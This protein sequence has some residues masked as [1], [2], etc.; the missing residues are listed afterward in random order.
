VTC[1]VVFAACIPRPPG[2]FYDAPSPLKWGKP[3]DLIW[4]EPLPVPTGAN[5][6]AWRVMY[7]SRDSDNRE[8]AVTGTVFLPLDAPPPGGW[9]IVSFAHGTSG[10]A[11]KCAPS[12]NG[13]STNTWG[14][15]GI[16]VATDY[17]GLGPTGQR[18][19]F[20]SGEAEG[21]SVIDIVR[22]VR[23]FP[24]AHA[25]RRWV[26]VGVSQGGHAS[27]FAGE[28]ARKYAPELKLEGVVADAPGSGLLDTYPD[29]SPLVVN[30]ITMMAL[31]G[32]AVDHPQIRPED[33]VTPRAA[34]A[35]KVL[36]TGCLA[37]FA[38]A[39]A[40]IPYEE[41]FTADPRTTS[42]AREAAEKN[43]PGNSPIGA[44]VLLVQGTADTTV[45]PARTDA[46]FQKLCRCGK[47]IQLLTIPGGTHDN[48]PGLARTQIATWLNDRLAGVSAPTNCTER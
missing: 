34:E 18:H 25:S 30:V 33:Y 8:P 35:A 20:L 14:I 24:Q 29:D 11:S 2:N 47:P 40:P 27:L 6:E 22:A 28:L 31:Y 4:A 17:I 46:L 32:I 15:K 9:P 39:L 16:V 21:H 45:V 19:A 38:V 41:L 26:T 3:G 12:R 5:A 42:P 10:M 7:H 36:D 48:T 1:V 43:N 37:D 23:Q 44:P 13:A